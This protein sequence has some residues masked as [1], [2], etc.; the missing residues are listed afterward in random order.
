MSKVNIPVM[1]Q[2][3]A[4]DIITPLPSEQM[5]AFNKLVTSDKYLSVSTGLPHAWVLLPLMQGLTN[6]EISKEEAAAIAR[7]YQ[8]IL[9]LSFFKV[10]IDRDE[11]YRSYLQASYI[12]TLSQDP[13]N[14][15]L[16]QSIPSQASW[17]KSELI[18]NEKAQPLYPI[19][20]RKQADR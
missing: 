11:E 16:V 4:E 14:L 6:K 19:L 18:S 9:A 13:Y 12:K 15:S 10:Y 20:E 5:P 1:W 7:D 8:N 3:A 2:A 17:H